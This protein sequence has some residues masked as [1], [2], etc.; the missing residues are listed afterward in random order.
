[1]KQAEHFRHHYQSFWNIS[2]ILLNPFL[3]L[4][5]F[6]ERWLPASGQQIVKTTFLSEESIWFF[7]AGISLFSAWSFYL[8][9]T[10]EKNL[11]FDYPPRFTFPGYNR[12]NFLES[13]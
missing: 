9:P 5:L 4:G 2:F 7:L 6:L 3:K 11:P 12:N 8:A 13:K 1:M 10:P